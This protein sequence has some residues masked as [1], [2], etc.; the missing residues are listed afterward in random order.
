[1]FVSFRLFNKCSSAG[2]HGVFV[3]PFFAVGLDS[4][5]SLGPTPSSRPEPAITKPGLREKLV[6]LPEGPPA[7]NSE[8]AL[9]RDL[10]G[11]SGEA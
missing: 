2:V 1:M 6:L 4:W 7:S 10:A 11:D 9:L 3:R 5:V 8:A